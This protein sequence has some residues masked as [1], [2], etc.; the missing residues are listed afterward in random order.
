MR[1]N[2]LLDFNMYESTLSQ[3]L[4][5]PDGAY[6]E[7]PCSGGAQVAEAAQLMRLVQ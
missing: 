6:A 5:Q 1:E 3:N 2:N 4:R 7:R